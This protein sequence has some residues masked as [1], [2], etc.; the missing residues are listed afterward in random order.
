MSLSAVGLVGSGDVNIKPAD[1]KQYEQGNRMWQ[2]NIQYFNTEDQKKDRERTE[3]CP[4][5]MN[6]SMTTYSWILSRK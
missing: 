4:K 3:V 5:S 1:G 6:D 2:Y